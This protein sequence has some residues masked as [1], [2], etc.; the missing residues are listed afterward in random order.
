M[1]HAPQCEVYRLLLSLQTSALLPFFNASPRNQR[2]V[3]ETRHV[4]WRR[5][6]A[7]RRHGRVVP[8]HLLRLWAAQQAPR[9]LFRMQC[10]HRVPGLTP[11]LS[12]R[13]AFPDLGSA[14]DCGRANEQRSSL[15]AL[16]AS[17]S[18]VRTGSSLCH[19]R[20]WCQ[21]APSVTLRLA[22][23]QVSARRDSRSPPGW[24]A[25]RTDSS[26]ASGL[27]RNRTRTT[28]SRAASLAWLQPGAATGA[29]AGPHLRS[30]R[31]RLLTR[32]NS[33]DP[34]T[35]RARQRRTAE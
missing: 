17:A 11:V 29:A 5:A 6:L 28:A 33:S 18:A 24:L 7:S 4:A 25:D 15:R 30:S 34:A 9:I 8:S 14:G 3:T 19:L 31:R 13:S 20:C 26:P 22:P 32:A 16:Y 12:L 35:G 23:L 1:L 27:R 10:P 21:R 2:C